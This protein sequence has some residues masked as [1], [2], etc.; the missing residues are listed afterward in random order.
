MTLEP[1]ATLSRY[2]LLEKLGEGG[3]GVVWKAFD[4]TLRREIAIKILPEAVQDDPGRL[5][6]FKHEARTVAAM[7]HPHIVTIFSIEE[8]DRRHFIT[9]ELIQGKTLSEAI[10][11]G[12][13]P[14][15]EFFRVA[16][17]ILDAIGAVHQKDIIHGD[18]KPPNIMLTEDGTIKVLD[19]G[20]AKFNETDPAQAEV[21]ATTVTLIQ[22]GTIS[23]TLPYMS[24]EQILNVPP[25]SRSDV[26]SIGIILY[27]MATGRRPFSGE[28]SNALMA[29]ILKDKPRPANELNPQI[30]RQLARLIG[31]CLEKESRNRPPS[32][33]EVRSEL[34]AAFRAAKS[35]ESGALPS[36][37]VLPFAD[38]SP[39]KDQDYFCEGIAE[40]I[41]NALSR[42]KDLRV[43]SRTSSFQFKDKNLDVR[44]IG[45]KLAVNTLLEGSI[46]KSANQ[47][48]IA[49]ELV[50]VADGY[51][52]WSDRYDREI[53]DIFAIQEEI[54][55]SIVEALM[56][57][58]SPKERRAIKQVATVDV[59][60]YDYYLRGRKYFFQSR[61]RSMEFAIQMFLQ[62]IEIDPSY[63]LAH[64][65]IADC[66]AYLYSNIEHNE[67]YRQQADASSRRAL[68]LDP[69][70][71]EA[72]VS[73]GLAL[74]L[75][76]RPEEAEQMF[77]E[78]T[79]LNP[80]LF[81]AYYFYARDAFSQGN[82]EKAI[83]LYK[84]ASELRPEDYQ[85]PLLVAQIYED[86]GRKDEAETA[87]RSGVQAAE[88]RLDLEPDDVRALYMG[89]NGLIALGEKERGLEWSRRANEL[90]PGEPMLLYNLACNYAMAG[91]SDR[92]L[93]CLEQAVDNGFANRRWLEHDSNLDSL[94]ELERFKKL[95]ECLG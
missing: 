10:P 26:F 32:A 81:E 88:G 69:D 79:R 91:E 14:L 58:L 3:M 22:D 39:E 68:E 43:A 21:E 15:Y 59:K 51:Q 7:S 40:E 8:T 46:R 24:P 89:A 1:G 90:E 85:A 12:G 5:E 54:A 9:M 25:D 93:A 62:A 30:P 95:L 65:G 38:M 34:G 76:N 23:G 53:K 67:A 17:P 57:S 78:A 75:L 56:L 16:T 18:L 74:S 55:Q 35:T 48:R 31:L 86:L 83:E 60:A 4:D 33:I 6:R 52:I 42:I 72:H 27:E 70:L 29:S 50:N 47:L 64:A 61:R 80:N 92:A 73:R 63:A 82:Q 20:L 84:R 45:D 66:A 11:P 2:R 13:F 71:A 19:F 28:T 37:A 77:E 94:R 36:I 44:E 49:V 87:R 41:I